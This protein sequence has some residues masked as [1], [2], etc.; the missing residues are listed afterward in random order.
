MAFFVKTAPDATSDNII[1]PTVLGVVA[2]TLKRFSTS[3]ADLLNCMTAAGVVTGFRLLFDGT[4]SCPDTGV[5]SER[6]GAGSSA[7]IAGGTAI[8]NGAIA[9][10]T[11]GNTVAVGISANATG[12]AAIAIGS[13]A[14]ASGFTS[15][16]I[17][18]FPTAT[19]TSA[20]SIG[21]GQATNTGAIAINGNATAS[22]AI[23]LTGTASATQAYAI[24]GT[25][26]G[27]QS[28]G[29]GQA[30]SINQANCVGIGHGVSITGQASVAIGDSTTCAF[31]DS[32][33][34]GFGA[35]A[36]SN[37]QVVIGSVTA[38]MQH[39]VLGGGVTNTAPPATDVQISAASGSNIAGANF[40]IDA[41]QSTGS[42]KGGDL[43][44]QVS[45]AGGA[46][47]TLNTKVKMLQ[48]AGDNKIGFFAAAPV[49]KQ[50]GAS[51]AGIAA[52]LDANAKA[53]VGALQTALANLG[54]VTSPA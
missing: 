36:T 6:Y 23:A 45:P 51:A 54:L 46:G 24:G 52:I 1:Q 10:G 3:V 32:C 43:I 39:I 34:L 9:G 16:A 38:P 30:V 27:T 44:F 35:T 21:T 50:T 13:S 4:P 17:G 47:S 53:A 26:S 22:G 15:I 25:V 19:G 29:I 42:A 5:G 18:N 28:V 48:L 49:V 37:N 11:N 41:G 31:Q 2:L 40:T 33:V 12:A 8:G 20:I 7:P 14:T